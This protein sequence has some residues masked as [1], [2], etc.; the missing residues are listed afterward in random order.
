[1]VF[2]LSCSWAESK[3][4]NTCRKKNGILQIAKKRR[5]RHFYIGGSCRMTRLCLAL[6]VVAASGSVVS[7]RY[8]SHPET[9]PSGQRY[10]VVQNCSRQFCRLE[11][12]AGS[13]LLYRR[14]QKSAFRALF[15][16]GGSCR[17]TQLCL[18]LRAVAAGGSVVSLRST[19][20]C[21]RFESF[22]LQIAKKRL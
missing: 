13:N 20:T 4:Q 14:K 3:E 18:A 5:Q 22:I 8:S 9:R 21:C 2:I 19:R 6:R 12:A 7:L 10:R 16:I 17:M 15:Y 1:M 11:P